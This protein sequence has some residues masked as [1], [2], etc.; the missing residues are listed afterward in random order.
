MEKAVI[1]QEGDAKWKTLLATSLETC[2]VNI[3]DLTATMM[4]AQ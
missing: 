2:N 3:N 1:W 4:V